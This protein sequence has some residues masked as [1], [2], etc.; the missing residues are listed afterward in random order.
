VNGEGAA[1]GLLWKREFDTLEEAEFAFQR[2]S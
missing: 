1:T 2:A